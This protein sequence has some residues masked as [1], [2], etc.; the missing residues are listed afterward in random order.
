LQGKYLAV[1]S[2]GRPGLRR[3]DKWGRTVPPLRENR[4]M[5]SCA[6]FAAFDQDA[7]NSGDK[8]DET[9]PQRSACAGRVGVLLYR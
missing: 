6:A 7:K 4:D 9:S 5:E 8:S 2:R 1:T 3:R